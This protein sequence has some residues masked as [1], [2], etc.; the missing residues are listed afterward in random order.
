MVTNMFDYAR[1]SRRADRR[2]LVFLLVA[3]TLVTGVFV[4][5]C[6]LGQLGSTPAAPIPGR[7]FGGADGHGP[8]GD[9][10][11]SDA[12]GGLGDQH[13]GGAVR[14]SQPQPATEN[15]I[16]ALSGDTSD[17]LKPGDSSSLDI[18]FTNPSTL[19]V[20]LTGI[21]VTIVSVSAPNQ[22]HLLHCTAA[23]YAIRQVPADFEVTV[24]AA[25]IVSLSS[26]GIPS[27][28]WPAV[29]MVNAARDQRGCSG[30][31]VTFDY[32]SE[33]SGS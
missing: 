24:P 2:T 27:A 25:A 4:A 30:A 6:L 15:V 17:P 14:G 5:A 33:G 23:D 18:T 1:S 28:S 9:G 8:A 19:P 32:S 11:L 20:T 21:Q 10:P 22:T 26:L 3:F 12:I 7:M 16:V 29:A 31:T 13:G